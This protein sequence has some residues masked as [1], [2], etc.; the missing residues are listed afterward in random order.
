ELSPR[1]C[2]EAAEL[3]TARF[4]PAGVRRRR[5]E[6]QGFAPL[7]LQGL[8]RRRRGAVARHALGAHEICRRSGRA[9]PREILSVTRTLLLIADCRLRISDFGLRISDCGPEV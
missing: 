9:R 2:L 3:R 1:D 7:R 6:R 5:P 4:S 8:S